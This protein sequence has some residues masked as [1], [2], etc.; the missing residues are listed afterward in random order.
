LAAAALAGA[1]AG[2]LA[3]DASAAAGGKAGEEL[4]NF[5]Y[6]MES[7]AGHVTKGGSAREA[8]VR[9]LPISTGL[10]G[11]SMRLNPGGLRELHWRPH[12][13]EWLY[14]VHGKVRVTVFGSKG[15]SRTEE[16]C[17]GDAGY[18]PA[19]FGHA[20][21]NHGDQPARLVIGFDSG[22]YQEI[23][24]STCLGANPLGLV[25]DN[26]ALTDA[27]ASKLPSR[28]QFT[29]PGRRPSS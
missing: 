23:S 19:G 27:D 28:R 24:L 4:P 16:F 5:R 29:V 8:T 7:Q 26:F 2:R 3:G 14:L 1:G 12:A 6:H 15:R 13:N 25:A 22:E 11:V 10:A 17:P 18:I 20:I 9:Q 21:E